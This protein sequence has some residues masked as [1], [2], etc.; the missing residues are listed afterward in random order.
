MGR[1]LFPSLPRPLSLRTVDTKK[2]QRSLFKA[3]NYNASIKDTG[4]RPG[5]EFSLKNK[6]LVTYD[7]YISTQGL[8]ILVSTKQGWQALPHWIFDID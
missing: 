5:L 4:V 8:C 2:I 7:C 6:K 3:L 1:A